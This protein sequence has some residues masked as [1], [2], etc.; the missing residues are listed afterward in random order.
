MKLIVM[1]MTILTLT[2]MLDGCSSAEYVNIPPEMARIAEEKYGG[3]IATPEAYR[4]VFGEPSVADSKYNGI[5]ATHEAY[6]AVTEN[7]GH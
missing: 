1:L 3:V 4:E 5:I 7:N 2:V 6:K